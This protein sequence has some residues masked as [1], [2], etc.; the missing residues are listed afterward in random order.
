MNDGSPPFPTKEELKR[1]IAD[2]E[3]DLDRLALKY[4]PRWQMDANDEVWDRARK[5]ER[6]IVRLQTRLD[7]AARRFES[8]FDQSS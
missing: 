1:L 6:K 4:Q 8:D 3:R 5:R 7:K 2:R